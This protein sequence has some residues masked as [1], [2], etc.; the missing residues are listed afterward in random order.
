MPVMSIPAMTAPMT[1]GAIDGPGA[2]WRYTGA[3]VIT[4]VTSKSGSSVRSPVTTG[5]SSSYA[6]NPSRSVTTGVSTKLYGGGGDVVSHS[7]VSAP[8]G[9]A[10]ASSPRFTLQRMLMARMSMDVAMMTE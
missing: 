1:S 8:H 7:S 9:L 6:H 2:R 3:V 5:T 4:A 10:P